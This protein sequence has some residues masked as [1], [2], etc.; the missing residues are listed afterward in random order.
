[1]ETSKPIII[2]NQGIRAYDA[3]NC[4]LCNK[5]GKA[6]YENMKDRISDA[7]GSW[8]IR[9]CPI[10]DIAWL[11]PCPALED[12]GKLYP[13]SYYTHSMVA[14][15]HPKGI[16][17]KIK[18]VKTKIRKTI[19]KARYGYN[20]FDQN[21]MGILA[22]KFPPFIEHIGRGILYLEHQQGRRLLDIG[23]GK[24]E[25]LSQMK[26]LGWQVMGVEPDAEAARIA[27]EKFQI[28]VLSGTLL[29][30]DIPNN[31]FDIVT[32][33]HVIEHLHNPIETLNRIFHILKPGGKLVI[34]TPNINSLV[35]VLMKKSWY[36]WDPPRHLL[37]FSPRSLKKV[38]RQVGFDIK[39]TRTLSVHAMRTW[40]GSEWIRR[41]GKRPSDPFFLNNAGWWMK[42]QGKLVH[43][44]E[45]V[46]VHIAKKDCGEELFLMALKPGN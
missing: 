25:F 33:Q 3:P 11:T 4:P 28:P 42:T 16:S 24:G 14:K 27:Q 26:D 15:A 45:T 20:F 29:E 44:I 5:E 2:N 37:L 10:C 7:P 17:G 6:L 36:P 40:I 31:Y 1:M 41:T 34:L 35:Q 21:W 30:N 13:N 38:V 9:C 32:M 23:C 22:A 39:E 18:T 8:D 43:L 19:Y 12:M 46:M